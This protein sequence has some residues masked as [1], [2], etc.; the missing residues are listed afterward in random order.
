MRRTWV[1]PLTTYC[2]CG[3]PYPLKNGSFHIWYRDLFRP[4]PS[5]PESSKSGVWHHH[6]HGGEEVED[7]DHHHFSVINKTHSEE[8]TVT[9]GVA[10]KMCTSFIK[11][12]KT[13][14]FVDYHLLDFLFQTVFLRGCVSYISPCCIPVTKRNTW[15]KH[16]VWVT[17]SVHI[18]STLGR[19]GSEGGRRCGSRNGEQMLTGQTQSG[20]REKG[21]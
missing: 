7:R 8:N 10:V 5:A 17:V 18:L 14:D 16:R 20:S 3:E 9:D 1:W 11:K 13:G 2:V 21:W 4:H 6:P 15:R 19:H 12:K